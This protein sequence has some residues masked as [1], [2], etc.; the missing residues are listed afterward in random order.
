MK[1]LVTAYQ[2]VF[3]L[4]LAGLC[5]LSLANR[6]PEWLL[7][8]EILYFCAICGGLGGALYCLRAVYL[9]ACVYKRWNTEWLPW[10]FIRPVVSMLS[11]LAAY[12]FLAAGLLVLDAEGRSNSFNYGF[13][14]VAFVAGL[15]VDKFIGKIEEV[16]ES[17]WG[18]KRSR[19]STASDKDADNERR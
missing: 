8:Y 7:P 16:A 15:N 18:I 19:A 13:Y 12:I 14:A 10:Y 2:I 9:N 3:L 1:S 11:G 4:A 5:Y 17:L 6:L